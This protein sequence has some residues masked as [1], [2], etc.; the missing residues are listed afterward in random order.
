MDNRPVR[1]P[2][3]EGIARDK[4]W[5]RAEHVVLIAS[6]AV[7][8]LGALA[9]VFIAPDSLNNKEIGLAPTAMSAPPCEGLTGDALERCLVLK[10]KRPGEYEQGPRD[11]DI[12]AS[13]T[14]ARAARGSGVEGVSSAGTTEAPRR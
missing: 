1:E 8:V 4:R 10:Q 7:L 9:F 14:A 2:P 11:S 3:E 5:M 13:S 6:L 12:A